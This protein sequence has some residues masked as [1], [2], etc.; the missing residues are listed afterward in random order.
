LNFVKLRAGLTRGA[1]RIEGFVDNLTN[2]GGATNLSLF[3]NVGNPFETFAKPDA[4]VAGIPELRTY[5][6]RVKYKFSL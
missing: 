3:Y 1:L 5:G 6:I 2:E 4:L